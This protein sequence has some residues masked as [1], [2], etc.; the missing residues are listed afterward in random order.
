MAEKVFKGRV[1]PDPEVAVVIK[2]PEDAP[3]S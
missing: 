2:V 3:K 1:K